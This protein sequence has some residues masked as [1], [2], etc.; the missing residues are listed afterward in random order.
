MNNVLQKIALITLIIT[1]TIFV[2][3]MFTISG[4]ATVDAEGV[5]VSP[6]SNSIVLVF[7]IILG[8]LYVGVSVYLLWSVFSENEK[9]KKIMLYR[10]NNSTASTTYSVAKKIIVRSAKQLGNVRIKKV[11]VKHVDNLLMLTVSISINSDEIEHTIDVLR[12]MLA[13]TF[14]TLLGIKFDTVNFEVKRIVSKYLPDMEKAEEKATELKTQRVT[15]E[16]IEE[17]IPEENEVVDELSKELSQ[18]SQET[19]ENGDEVVNQD[20]AEKENEEGNTE[21]TAPKETTENSESQPETH[22]TETENKETETQ[23]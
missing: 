19:V 12:C 13:D 14:Y 22:E 10:D 4:W 15:K 7:L 23:E 9:L 1:G 8:V 16:K 5:F 3:L 11:K 18:E 2:V 21:T 6:L 17:D 20:I